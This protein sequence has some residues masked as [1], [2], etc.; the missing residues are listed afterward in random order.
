MM[1]T[2]R[3]Q[4]RGRHSLGRGTLNSIIMGTRQ[5]INSREGHCDGEMYHME[6]VTTGVAIMHRM[7]NMSLGKSGVLSQITTFYRSLDRMELMSE[8]DPGGL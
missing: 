5:A 2:G 6:N 4:C 3:A 1:M 7:G 8:S